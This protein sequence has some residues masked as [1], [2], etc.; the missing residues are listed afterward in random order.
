MVKV[1]VLPDLGKVPGF[2]TELD[3]AAGRFQRHDLV[4]RHGLEVHVLRVFGEPCPHDPD[5]ESFRG[6]HRVKLLLRLRE[7]LFGVHSG[8]SLEI[9]EV[10][11]IHPEIELVQVLRDLTH[12]RMNSSEFRIVI[13]ARQAQAVVQ[14]RHIDDFQVL[15]GVCGYSIFEE[16]FH[17]VFLLY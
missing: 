6:R 4:H 10:E 14:H 2:H 16:N 7:V 5:K 3:A 11:G 12:V 13:L 15:A 8:I 17:F 9:R 1:C